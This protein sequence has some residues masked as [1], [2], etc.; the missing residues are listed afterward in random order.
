MYR[1]LT[2]WLSVANTGLT[3]VKAGVSRKQCS[4]AE[5]RCGD[6]MYHINI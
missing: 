5:V 3:G 4:L 1:P 2:G 6:F